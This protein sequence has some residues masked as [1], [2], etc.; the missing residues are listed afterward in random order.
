[1]SRELPEYPGY[2]ICEDGVIIGRFGRP[3]KPRR[4][5]K[6]LAVS[7]SLGNE[8]VKQ[9]YIHR[10]VAMAWLPSPIRE[11]T[12]V[13]HNDGNPHNNAAV[14]LRWATPSENSLDQIAHGTRSL[15]F[16]PNGHDKEALGVYVYRGKRLC[17]EC[18]READRRRKGH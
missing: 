6:Y 7:L 14:N 4:V 16:C 18:R 11:R 5:G 8:G 1:M 12:Q 3:L 15:T 17:M 10:L 2:R 9:E 13:A